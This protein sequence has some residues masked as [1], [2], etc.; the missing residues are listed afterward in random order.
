MITVMINSKASNSLDQAFDEIIA[1]R[2]S[3]WLLGSN[4]IKDNAIEQSLSIYKFSEFENLMYALKDNGLNPALDLLKNSNDIATYGYQMKNGALILT[5]E[6]FRLRY[7][8]D[9]NLSNW[10]D[11]SLGFSV[12]STTDL[13]TYL[14]KL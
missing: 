1:A 13:Q 7:A 8:S 10:V 9:R 6:K 3:S 11:N 4:S 14:N 5:L 12:Y 2:Q